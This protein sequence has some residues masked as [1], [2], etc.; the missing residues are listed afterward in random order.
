MIF[1]PTT[2][3]SVDFNGATLIL[4][5]VSSGNVAQLAVD[6]LISTL[7]W[8]RLGVFDSQHLVPFVAPRED[9]AAGITAPLELHGKPGSSIFALQQRSPVMKTHKT[10]FL[11]LLIS[12]VERSRF[13]S[14]II[15]SGVDLSERPDAHMHTPTFHIFPGAR[16]PS[17]QLPGPIREIVATTPP[18][19]ESSFTDIPVIPGSGL[20]RR[21]LKSIP[22]SFPPVIAILEYVLEGD[23]RYDARLLAA[24]IAKSLKKD[25]G[26][27]PDDQWREPASW[28]GGLFGSNHDQALFG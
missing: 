18:F 20:L 10:Q 26:A 15:L 25:L 28:R 16:V 4:P 17:K 23:N 12:F 9:G 13:S 27:I 22:D 3:E 19:I 11:D 6:L 24:A 2:T 21:V 8:P 14:V 5:I 1:F 7:N